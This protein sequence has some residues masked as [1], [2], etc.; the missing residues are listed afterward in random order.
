MNEASLITACLSNNEMAQKRLFDVHAP[1]VYG[2]CL[3]YASCEAEAN[4]MMQN[5]FIKVFQKLPQF[6][7]TGSLG[8]W[9]RKI[10]VNTCLDEIRKRKTSDHIPL[11][12][13]ESRAHET[14][15]ALTNIRTQELL[16]LVQKLPS[17]YR[18]VFNMFAIEGYSHRE[19]A[20]ELNITENTSKSQYRKARL[21]LQEALHAL[22]KRIIA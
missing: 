10:T 20:D 13:A 11:E 2:V 4:D 18:T 17:G 16:S 5:A 15:N 14:Q 7:Q 19:I 3:R 8:G 22:D 9:I 6:N 12:F 21:W 1:K